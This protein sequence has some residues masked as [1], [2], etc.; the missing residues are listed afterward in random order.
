MYNVFPL[1]VTGLLIPY[2]KSLDNMINMFVPIFKYGNGPSV[3]DSYT[4][5]TRHLNEL[6][7]EYTRQLIM[8][9]FEHLSTIYFF[10]SSKYFKHFNK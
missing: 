8:K 3:K 7:E 5:H 4:N 9:K 1:E 6:H 10:S 2:I